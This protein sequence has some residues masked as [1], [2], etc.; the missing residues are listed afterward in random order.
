MAATDQIHPAWGI[1]LTEELLDKLNATIS[2]FFQRRII[3]GIKANPAIVADLTKH[4]QKIAFA[5][6]YLDNGLAS[7]VVG[8]DELL[9]QGRGVFL[10]AR[11]EV[12][13]VL[14][15]FCVVHLPWV[16]GAIVY[17]TISWQIF[18][19]DITTRCIYCPLFRWPLYITVNWY[20][21]DVDNGD[22]F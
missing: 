7:Q 8:L 14:I 19:A 4:F 21:Q 22:G 6:A 9:G 17:V 10:K 1:L 5:R 16:E 15:F 13:R 11:R 2:R 3:A 12:Q 20:I 18:Q